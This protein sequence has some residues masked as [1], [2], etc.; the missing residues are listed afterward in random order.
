[1]AAQ[2]KD[3]SL[4]NGAKQNDEETTRG[5]TRGNTDVAYGNMNEIASMNPQAAKE[6]AQSQMKQQFG[7]NMEQVMTLVPDSG[8]KTGAPTL[9]VV[10]GTEEVTEYN[11]VSTVAVPNMTPQEAMSQLQGVL[12]GYK[13]EMDFTTNEEKMEIY[14]GLVFIDGFYAVHFKIYMITDDKNKET[15]W[16]LRRLSGNAM[17]SAKFFGQIK[18]AFFAKDSEDESSESKDKD[19][20]TALE[21]LPLNT[22]DMKLEL[23]DDQKEM[24]MIHE[25]LLSDEVG[26]EMDEKAETYL[27]SK[28]AECGAISKDIQKDGAIDEGK[29]V[30][31]LLS[32][33][34]MNHKDVAVQRAA[35][36]IL[37]KFVSS[38]QKEMVEAGL[39]KMLDAMAKG[40]KYSSITKRV[41]ALKKLITSE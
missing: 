34:V 21:A 18:T 25:A 41:D 27:V 12:S 33:E 19:A 1:M 16:E 14:D 26:V 39:P 32:N 23:S 29:L 13:G 40:T 24:M 11:D 36:M 7:G 30:E 15:R 38:K 35:L 37:T 17:A 2:Q 3:L 20:T 4:D 6:S 22:D 5:N 9:E 28:L 10:Q 8:V 31:T